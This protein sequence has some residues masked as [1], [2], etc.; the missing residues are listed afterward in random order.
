M[1]DLDKVDIGSIVMLIS[2]RE[3]YVVYR[4]DDKVRDVYFGIKKRLYVMSLKDR[5]RSTISVINGMQYMLIC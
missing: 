2:N 4:I 1:I 5:Y 3:M